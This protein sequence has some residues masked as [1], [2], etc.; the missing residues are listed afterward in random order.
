MKRFEEQ[1]AFHFCDAYI[2]EKKDRRDM[3]AINI[4]AYISWL[5]D[6]TSFHEM[7]QSQKREHCLVIWATYVHQQQW[8][9]EIKKRI[10]QHE[11]LVYDLVNKR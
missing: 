3:E 2:N 8:P 5:S 10:P 11:I 6:A 1:V 9:N 7:N 4:D